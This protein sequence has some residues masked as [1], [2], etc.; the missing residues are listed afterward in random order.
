MKT[1][2]VRDEAKKS[3]DHAQRHLIPTLFDETAFEIKLQTLVPKSTFEQW[4][5]EHQQAIQIGVRHHLFRLAR[6]RRGRSVQ[7]LPLMS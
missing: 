2:D 4:Q 7:L 6:N 5:Q 1:F 3:I